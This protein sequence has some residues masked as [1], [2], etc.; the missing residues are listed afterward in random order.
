MLSIS[1]TL[2]IIVGIYYSE[3]TATMAFIITMIP[4]LIIGVFLAGIKSVN[5]L[6]MRDSA[7][8][9]SVAWFLCAIIG[10]F[11]LMIS[12]S[13][14]NFFD[15]FF[16]MCSG[17]S[18]TGSTIITDVEAMP[19]VILFWRTL[20]HWLGGI[21][22]LIFTIAL[23]PAIGFEGQQIA[24]AEVAAPTLSKVVPKLSQASRYLCF[25]YLGLTALQTVLLMF[26]GMSLFDAVTH[27]FSTLGTG[28][29]GNYNDS[30]A[31]FNS[32]YIDV[33]IMIFMFIA[34]MNFGLFFISFKHGL[35]VFYQDDEWKTYFKIV[36]ISGLIVSGTIM[37][38]EGYTPGEALKLGF[39]HDISIITTTGF[40]L[41]NYSVW[42]T[43]SQFMLLTLFFIGGCSSSTGGG[44]KV[45]RIFVFLKI[46]KRAIS[47]RLHQNNIIQLKVN[48]HKLHS[49]TATNIVSFILT[50][51]S[52]GLLGTLLISVDGKSIISCL[53]ATFCCLGNIGIAFEELGPG[54]SFAA[55]SSF[56]KFVLS[57]LM[58][59]GRLEVFTVLVL[60]SKRFWNPFR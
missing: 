51:I 9:V 60:L 45:I 57:I 32:S 38:S 15:S 2:P 35:K 43:L 55:L 58:I 48:N 10:T 42:H 56:S 49:T 21:G 8:I 23:L 53:S 39:F 11:P 34:G 26:G 6:K 29:F 13:V 16:E 52:L 36:L 17:F 44:I 30:I 37:L 31:H 46:I 27:S 1:M 5:R 47:T 22:I 28:G 24:A 18:T 19:K 40:T 59:A 20:T 41:T 4:T 12:G 14:P 3:T 7:L 33:V 54:F 50:Y 25:L